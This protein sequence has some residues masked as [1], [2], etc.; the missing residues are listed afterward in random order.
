MKVG[1]GWS[2]DLKDGLSV[3]GE[4]ADGGMASSV[5]GVLNLL[6]LLHPFLFFRHLGLLFSCF[7]FSR[8]SFSGVCSFRC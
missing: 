8:F 2:V 5:H 4:E 7:V 6:L 1:Q 3:Q